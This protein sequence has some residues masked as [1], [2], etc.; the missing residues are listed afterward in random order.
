MICNKVRKYL[1]YFILNYFHHLVYLLTELE[2]SSRG[3]MYQIPDFSRRVGLS[4]FYI[5]GIKWFLFLN[6][7]S[8]K[9]TKNKNGSEKWFFW[10]LRKY[11][12]CVQ[13]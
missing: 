8:Y 5:D 11:S 13:E 1:I 10:T 9:A 2:R 7:F 3:T 6:I 4:G 12:E